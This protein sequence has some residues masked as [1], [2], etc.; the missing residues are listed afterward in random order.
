MG[1]RR[2]P[3]SGDS[4][5]AFDEV[6]GQDQN[7]IDSGLVTLSAWLPGLSQSSKIMLLQTEEKRQV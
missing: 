2:H 6:P 4:A 7:N 1:R 5:L 3:H